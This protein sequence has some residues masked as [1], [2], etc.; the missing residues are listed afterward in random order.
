MSWNI[1]D[2]QEPFRTK[3]AA[4]YSALNDDSHLT[5]LGIARFLIVETKRDIDVHL[6]YA[7][8]LMA[9]YA[10][11]E[12]RIMALDFV[13]AM[14][15][16]AGLYAIGDRE[17]LTPNTWTMKSK[18][19]EGLAIDIA[20]SKDGVNFWWAPPSW[21]GWEI[22]AE[23]AIAHKIEPGSR[24]KGRRDCPHFEEKAA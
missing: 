23:I 19:L 1:A 14:Y 12:Y 10:A 20:P 8:R 2:L 24:W 16:R 18:H 5:Q 4:F 6:A 11:T 13:K 15:K 3:A 21:P 17:A 22:M 9:K 7:S